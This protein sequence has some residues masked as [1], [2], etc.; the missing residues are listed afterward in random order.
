MDD[1][2]PIVAGSIF[3][4]KTRKG[5]VSLTVGTRA[6]VLMTP[7][8]A[9][10]VAEDILQACTAAETDEVLMTWLHTRM[11]MDDQRATLVLR[12][13]R[14]LREE[15]RARQPPVDHV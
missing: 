14:Q 2:S 7:E 4:A 8:E 10:S 3:G 15:R 6:P 12:D 9:R 13:L 5:L 11:D 1:D